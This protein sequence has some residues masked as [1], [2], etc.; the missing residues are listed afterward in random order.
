MIYT[1]PYWPYIPAKR[2][3]LV[4]SVLNYQLFSPSPSPFPRSASLQGQKGERQ[5]EAG[6]RKLEEGLHKHSW[7]ITPYKI[8]WHLPIHFWVFYIMISHR[9]NHFSTLALSKLWSQ[10]PT[11]C[12]TSPNCAL[13]SPS[14]W[15]SGNR[16]LLPDSMKTHSAFWSA[17]FLVCVWGLAAQVRRIWY[18]LF[19]RTNLGTSN[20][21]LPVGLLSSFIILYTQHIW[22]HESLLLT[23]PMTLIETTPHF[24]AIVSSQ[25]L[26]SFW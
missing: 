10:L 21:S 3:W 23:P 4:H 25:L 14:F 1:V 20:V 7:L 13:M 19:W 22:W 6:T 24:C 9:G 5:G 8:L 15:A 11:K 2:V 18:H 12:F 16:T 26:L 17:S